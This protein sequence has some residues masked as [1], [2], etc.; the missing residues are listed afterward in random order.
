MLKLIEFVLEYCL[1]NKFALFI[2]RSVNVIT[3]QNIIFTN[4]Y[5]HISK[6]TRSHKAEPM[7]DHED[8]VQQLSPL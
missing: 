5:W 7:F 1:T 4:L 3:Q 2:Q 6:G 8:T